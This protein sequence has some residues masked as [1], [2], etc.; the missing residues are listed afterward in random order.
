MR[1]FLQSS[2]GIKINSTP[3]LNFQ[4]SLSAWPLRRY[5]LLS[6]CLCCRQ[7][8][9]NS[10]TF[11]T[12]RSTSLQTLNLLVIPCLSIS[13]VRYQVRVV[14]ANSLMFLG[15]H[16]EKVAIN[17]IFGT[18]QKSPPLPSFI[19]GGSANIAFV[20]KLWNCW[21][22]S[23]FSKTPSSREILF[24]QE[25]FQAFLLYKLLCMFYI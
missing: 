14:K 13:A 21:N 10:W 11:P 6:S 4:C 5:H 3:L 25:T 22:G 2:K 7:R 17:N 12:A 1:D 16:I 15:Y 8:H 18:R 19:P 9:R 24:L 20:N 23:T